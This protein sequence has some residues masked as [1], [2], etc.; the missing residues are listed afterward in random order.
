MFFSKQMSFHR[1]VNNQVHISIVCLFYFIEIPFFV[2]EKI[3][4]RTDLVLCNMWFRNK[5]QKKKNST[6]VSFC[7]IQTLKLTYRDY[8][9]WTLLSDCIFWYLFFYLLLWTLWKR[10][11][12]NWLILTLSHI[13]WTCIL[14]NRGIFQGRGVRVI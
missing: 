13:R 9:C 11:I 8:Y 7:R 3:I 2:E 5:K 1:S 10:V 6:F 14:E 4:L 12:T